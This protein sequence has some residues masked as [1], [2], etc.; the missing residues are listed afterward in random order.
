MVLR[1]YDFVSSVGAILYR[2]YL[3][4]H[5]FAFGSRN[6]STPTGSVELF[7][8]VL[9]K[10][11]HFSRRD[12]ISRLFTTTRLCLWVA[13]SIRAYR[14]GSVIQL[15]AS[16]HTPFVGAILYRAYLR[17]HGFAFWVAESIRAYR[18]G[19]VIQLGASK[20]TPFSRRD[21]ISRL[22]YDHTALPFG[23][24][25]QS[26]PTELVVLFNCELQNIPPFVGAILHRAC[27]TT[28]R[29]CLWV[30]ESIRAYRIG[31]VIQLGASKHIPFVGAILYRAYLRRFYTARGIARI[32]SVIQLGGRGINPRL[33]DW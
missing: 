10:T 21:F 26:A 28:T 16:K 23:S 19:G 30:A 5:G 22:F 6:K 12:F 9:P 33:Q 8:A 1:R 24:R 32:G 14:I 18:I 17:Q 27:F 11:R 2:A 15:G 20:H 25:N 31:S 4:R 3:R 29:L 13:E 7:Q